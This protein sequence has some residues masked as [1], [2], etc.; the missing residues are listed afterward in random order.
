[1]QQEKRNDELANLIQEVKMEATI[2]SKGVVDNLQIIVNYVYIYIYLFFIRLLF[3]VCL[4]FEYMN[5][6]IFTV[7][8]TRFV[9]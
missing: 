3:R 8:Y 2:E 1:M 7:L 5:T 4:F 9:C 6:C